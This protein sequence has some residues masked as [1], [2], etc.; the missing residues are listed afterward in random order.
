M[1]PTFGGYLSGAPG[2]ASP[3]AT[4][5]PAETC[6]ASTSAAELN[7]AVPQSELTAVA[8]DGTHGEQPFDTP[9]EAPPRV[10]QVLETCSAGVLSSEPDSFT[11]Q[12]QLPTVASVGTDGEHLSDAS[13]EAPPVLNDA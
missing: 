6:S 7:S 4:H 10:T 8:S 2:E 13:S 1:A 11:P 5:A 9:N 3:G 12:S